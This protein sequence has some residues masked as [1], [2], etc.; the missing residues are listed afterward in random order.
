MDTIQ[1]SR[2]ELFE[3]VWQ[4]P[5]SHLAKDY[6]ISDT[7]LRKICTRLKIPLP[8][9]GHWARLR[10]GKTYKKPSLPKFETK[11]QIILEKRKTGEQVI[12]EKTFR[13]NQIINE[14]KEQYAPLLSENE[15]SGV[16]HPLFKSLI[17]ELKTKKG[18]GY[19]RFSDSWEPSRGEFDVR[20]SRSIQNKALRFLKKFLYIID[21]RGHKI[22]VDWGS[23]THLVIGEARLKIAL[24]ERLKIVKEKR[25]TWDS[26]KY[27]PTGTLYF[28]N[29][30]YSKK[31]WTDEKESLELQ[32][33]KIISYLEVKAQELNRQIL[34]NRERRR[35]HEEQERRKQQIL[36]NKKIEFKNFQELIDKANRWKQSQI[37]KDYINHIQANEKELD[38]DWIKWAMDKATWLDPTSGHEDELLGKYPP[39][40]PKEQNKNW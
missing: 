12:S 20:F 13:Q 5:F 15:F 30:H 21:L 2:E 14:I 19:G 23:T 8:S 1:L 22:S 6:Q 4:K 16:S 28:Q 39:E 10:L 11:E 27:V 26:Q 18:D 37:L 33:P 25:G 9:Q 34:E 35:I 24:K 32:I 38:G 7:G 29:D 17:E 40:F 31:E 36:E 3:L